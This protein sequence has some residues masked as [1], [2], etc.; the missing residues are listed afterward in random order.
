MPFFIPNE[1]AYFLSRQAIFT[2][3]TA[4]FL[5]RRTIFIVATAYFLPRRAIFTVTAAYF[6]PRRAIF[7]VKTA[8]FEFRN[9]QKKIESIEFLANQTTDFEL[10]IEHLG[11]P[12]KYLAKVRLSSPE[13]QAVEAPVSIMVRHN[14]LLAALLRWI[15]LRQKI[16]DH[17]NAQP[18]EIKLL[19]V[20][21]WL[22]ASEPIADRSAQIT[23]LDGIE[24]EL[25]QLQRVAKVVPSKD[26]LEVPTE[27]MP[28]FAE[29]RKA[30]KRGECLA[31][32][33]LTIIAVAS[34][35]QILY[36]RSLIWGDTNDLL[37]AVLWGLG[38]QV[39]GVTGFSGIDGLRNLFSRVAG[40]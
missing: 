30:L 34:G 36:F 31:T 28:S 8:W 21:Q 33:V 26:L 10:A 27:P 1:T 7:T 14:W 11:G 32:L 6:L 22:R 2:V 24:T 38:I 39:A 9:R 35:L 16:D 4:Y 3:A 17:G 37:I 19:P 5:P 29:L 23:I 12:G 15:R 20:G 25:T 13:W 18:L 40:S